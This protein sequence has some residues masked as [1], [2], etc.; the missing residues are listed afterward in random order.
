MSL[1]EDF[2]YDIYND[3]HSKGISEEFYKQLDKMKFQDKHRY[4]SVRDTWEYAYNK[5]TRYSKEKID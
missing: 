3:V 4:K 5:I 2:Y 1:C